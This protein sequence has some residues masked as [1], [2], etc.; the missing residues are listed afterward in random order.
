ML[1]NFSMP[2][3]GPELQYIGHLGRNDLPHGL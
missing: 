3:T 2:L 1:N